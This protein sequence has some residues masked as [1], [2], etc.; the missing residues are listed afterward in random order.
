V[1]LLPH[2]DPTNSTTMTRWHEMGSDT[3]SILFRLV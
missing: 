2:Q 1:P 3:C